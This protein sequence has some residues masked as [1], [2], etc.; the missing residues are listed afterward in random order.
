MCI[1]FFS[2]LFD[3][4]LVYAVIFGKAWKVP[5]VIRHGSADACQL[6]NSARRERI[7]HD[8]QA[9]RQEECDE[10]IVVVVVYHI[11]LELKRNREASIN[12]ISELVV[13]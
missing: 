10:C 3:G 8:N 13:N 5:L 4:A 11:I 6:P 7:K 9:H 1:L 2:I 12:F